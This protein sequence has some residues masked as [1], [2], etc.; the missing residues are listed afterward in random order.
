MFKRP[1]S[2]RKTER[3]EISLNLVPILDTMVT[4]IAFVLFSMSFL[5]LVSVESPF[6]VA[7]ADP[8]QL[9]EKPLQLTLSL[10]GDSLELWCPFD[11]VPSQRI[12]HNDEG[13]PNT[14]ELHEKLVAIKQKFPLERQIILVPEPAV[15]YDELVAIMDSVRM[16]EATDPPI[17]VRDPSTGNDIAL[18]A[19]F[20]DVV[21]G[22]LL[23]GA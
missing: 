13:K 9:K 15:S 16:L 18:R 11:R 5:A 14:L 20:P 21:F 22:N 1:S 23:G 17:F 10:N 19:L 4:L 2:R 7:S 3:E 12:R 6:P 8:K